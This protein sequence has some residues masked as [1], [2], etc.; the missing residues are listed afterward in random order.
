[1]LKVTGSDL[2]ASCDTFWNLLFIY[3]LL[4]L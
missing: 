4:D 2:V 3:I 1:M